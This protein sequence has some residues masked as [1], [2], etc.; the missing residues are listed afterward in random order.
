MLGD[1]YG[2][3]GARDLLLSRRSERHPTEI[4]DL[5]GKRL[6]VCAETGEGRGLAEDHVKALT[7]ADVLKA[8]RIQEN[9]WRFKPT[10]KLVL[11]T[12]HRPVIKGTDLAIWRRLRL[13][14]F[15]VTIPPEQQDKTLPNKLLTELPGILAWCVRGCIE[16]Q[17]DGLGMPEAVQAATA[18]Y[19]SE[20]DVIGA[21]LAECCVVGLPDYKVKASHLYAAFAT[22]CQQSGEQ[23]TSQ[24]KFGEAMSERGI[25]RYMSAGTWYKNVAIRSVDDEGT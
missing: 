6:V 18:S 21:F 11:C 2:I 14:P 23:E 25:E 1:D 22:W 19:R 8:R 15:G 4:A 24:R 13:V 12:N 20:Q 3:T 9:F 17:R 16:W 5:F 7:G 10:H